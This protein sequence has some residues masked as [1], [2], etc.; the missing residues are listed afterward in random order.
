[1]VSLSQKLLYLHPDSIP[2]V[3]WVVRDDGAGE[4]IAFWNNAL[5]PQ[6]T[7]AELDAITEAQVIAGAESHFAQQEKASATQSVDD[8]TQI[9]GNRIE[10]I[11]ISVATSAVK[12]INN[13][14][15]TLGQMNA[16]VQAATSL[17]DLKTRFAA[18]SFPAQ[19]TMQQLKDSI[20]ADIAT[21]PE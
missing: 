5:G 1:M 6:P 3:D 20:K 13:D 19:I 7:Q 9:H 18:I 14:R 8:A 10:R 4:F 11:V 17:A 15:T 21:T 12:V 16:A 2:M